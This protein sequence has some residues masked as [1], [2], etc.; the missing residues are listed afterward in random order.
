MVNLSILILQIFQFHG[1]S[2]KSIAA[3]FQQSACY[4][5][6]YNL[7][8]CVHTKLFIPKSAPEWA[9]RRN[10]Q[11]TGSVSIHEI[12]KKNTKIFNESHCL[13]KRMNFS[14][15]GCLLY[16]TFLPRLRCLDQP[17]LWSD[18]IQADTMVSLNYMVWKKVWP[19]FSLK[20]YVKLF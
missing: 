8:N 18:H 6:K 15:E 4:I 19:Q 7:L 20:S 9:V 1:R 5:L 11:L 10:Y 14:L 13:T 17:V 3:T 16:F 2:Q 12:A